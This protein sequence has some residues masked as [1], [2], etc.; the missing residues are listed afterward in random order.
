MDEVSVLACDVS[1]GILFQC[2]R[3]NI[4]VL[5]SKVKMSKKKNSATLSQNIGS[6]YSVMQNFIPEKLIASVK[7]MAIR[8]T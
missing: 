2:L 1:L 8:A 7:H 4:V 3:G 5:S 6:K